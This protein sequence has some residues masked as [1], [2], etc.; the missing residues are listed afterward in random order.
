MIR[1]DEILNPRDVLVNVPGV[2]KKRVLET[3]AKLVAQALPSLDYADVFECLVER[4]RLGSTGFGNGIAIPHCRL[5][6]LNQ[7]FSVVLRLDKPIDFDAIDSIPVDLL[8][9]LV[10]PENAND[11]H[12]QLLRQIA[13]MLSQET[14]RERMR[15]APDAPALYQIVLD[16]LPQPR[17]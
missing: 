5:P 12:L 15:S 3:I 14:V 2:S 17:E 16:S 13:A 8:V 1:L 11:E 7:A 9:V 4:E 10:V 6:N